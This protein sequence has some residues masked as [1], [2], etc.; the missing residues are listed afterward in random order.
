MDCLRNENVD[1]A[2]VRSDDSGP[3]TPWAAVCKFGLT[4][5]GGNTGDTR[6]VVDDA[7]P[8]VAVTSDKLRVRY[9]C[10]SIVSAG[11]GDGDE[12]RRWW[13]S[14]A[15]S[16]AVH[17]AESAEVAAFSSACCSA[18]VA[19]S[20]A[21]SAC[22]V[23]DG[24]LRRRASCGA[25][26]DGTDPT[27]VAASADAVDDDDDDGDD[28][29]ARRRRA[30]DASPRR[31]GGASGRSGVVSLDDTW[32][33]GDE[34]DSPTVPSGAVGTAG[35]VALTEATGKRTDAT[36]SA[37]KPFKHVVTALRTAR[38]RASTPFTDCCACSELGLGVVTGGDGECGTPATL[39]N[40][41]DER[42]DAG[43]LLDSFN[44][45]PRLAGGGTPYA[46]CTACSA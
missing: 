13:A 41:M 37:G 36:T 16:R 11:C 27:D 1:P 3:T 6:A 30:D 22:T 33:A 26:V 10:K 35:P 19:S 39:G 9:A 2:D 44:T 43:V 15:A 46:A 24:T 21:A 28:V 5:S 34:D 42:Q 7:A 38:K 29:D 45:R 18:A 25:P 20:N 8:S 14:Y 32:V 4:S 17:T 40:D 31:D 12:N 23:T